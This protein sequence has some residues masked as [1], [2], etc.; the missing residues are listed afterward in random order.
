MILLLDSTRSSE[1]RVGLLDKRLVVLKRRYDHPASSQL[2]KLVDELLQ[3]HKVTVHD[4]DGLAAANG[5]GPFSALRTACALANAVSFASQI[6]AVG[7][8]GELT[9]KQLAEQ[10]MKKL[11]KA[12]HGVPVVPFYGRSPNITKVKR[13]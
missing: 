5:P 8:R 1:L 9:M 3:K 7:V 4:I 12:K 2:L 6:P 13:R 11:K 10:G